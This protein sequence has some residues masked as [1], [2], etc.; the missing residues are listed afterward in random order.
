MVTKLKTL[1][2][3]YRE[4][5]LYLIFGGLTTVVD[6]V[7]SFLL[8]GVWDA[9]INA[10]AFVIHGANV[11]AWV[12]AVLFAY[13]TN[14][15]WVFR[16]QQRGVLPILGELCTFAGGRIIT[17][18]LQEALVAVFFDWIGLNKYAVKLIAAVLVVILN[19]IISKLLVFRRMGKD[20]NE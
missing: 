17:F 15:I 16:S 14:R 8:Y 13:V 19:Y 2:H 6:W 18:L 9:A 5:L 20:E 12:S 4:Q 7:I 11:I 10:N 1:C 3:R